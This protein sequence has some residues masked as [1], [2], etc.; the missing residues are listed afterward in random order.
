MIHYLAEDPWPLAGALAALGM[1][2][3]I[4]LR[5]TQRGAYLVRG[6]VCL[7]LAGAVV[8]IEQAWVTDAE[9]IEWV[10]HD[11]ARAVRD[12]NPDAAVACL[13]PEVEIAMGDDA[14]APDGVLNVE[15]FRTILAGLHFDLLRVSHLETEAFPRSGTGRATFDVMATGRTTGP[16]RSTF[17]A[18]KTSWD[19]G[20]IRTGPGVWKVRRI[21]PTGVGDEAAT[22]YARVA[23]GG[24][25]RQ[26]TR[27][28]R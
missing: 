12:S 14:D 27:P 25:M 6:V 1:V 21:S 13:A 3:L 23:L 5:V 4:A 20:F 15:G 9:R 19:L 16:D 18:A 24:L 8:A 26:F 28:G 2:F 10:V 17:G 7:A 22:S 11:L